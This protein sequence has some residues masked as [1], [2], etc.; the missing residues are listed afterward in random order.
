M[1]PRARNCGGGVTIDAAIVQAAGDLGWR[2]GRDGK[3]PYH[4]PGAERAQAPDAMIA[5][6]LAAAG[7]S[8]DPASVTPHDREAI[9][10]RYASGWE[11]GHAER[12]L[13]AAAIHHQ[14]GPEPTAPGVERDR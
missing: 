9:D 7:T 10:E 2:H 13:L 6:V 12:P 14:L 3:T 11:R 4:A 1:S 5:D 8:R